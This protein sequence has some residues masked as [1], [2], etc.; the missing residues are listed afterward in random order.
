MDMSFASM[1]LWIF[2]IGGYV[3]GIT[4]VSKM[5]RLTKRIEQLE[6]QK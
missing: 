2:A 5:Y 4:A 6:K 1:M 3:L